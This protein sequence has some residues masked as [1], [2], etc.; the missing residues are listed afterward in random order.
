VTSAPEIWVVPDYAAPYL[1]GGVR[2]LDAVPAVR[3]VGWDE[4]IRGE[5]TIN[6][7]RAGQGLPPHTFR[8]GVTF[9]AHSMRDDLLDSTVGMYG[10]CDY[11]P[12]GM[13]VDD[14]ISRWTWGGGSA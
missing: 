8:A 3:V 13:R 5:K 7:Y 14:M 1:R 4:V 10:T 9:G 6:E 2:T 12:S 11:L